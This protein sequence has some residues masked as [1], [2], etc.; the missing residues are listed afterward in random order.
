MMKLILKILLNGKYYYKIKGSEYEMK[1]TIPKKLKSKSINKEMPLLMNKL[2][3][4]VV[5]IDGDW[6]IIEINL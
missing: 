2:M 6:H 1:K 5:L 3:K 4:P